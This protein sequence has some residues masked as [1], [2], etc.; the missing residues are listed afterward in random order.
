MPLAA[1][2]IT[3]I[4][5]V[6]RFVPH[7]RVRHRLDYGGATTLAIG[8]VP[9]SSSPNRAALGVDRPAV[10][11]HV[12]ARGRGPDPLRTGGTPDGDAALLP[13]RL[14]RVRSFRLGTTLHFIVAIGMFGATT[15]LP[16]YLQLVRGMSPMRAGLATLPTVAANLVITLVVGRLISRTGRFKVHLVA[17]VGSFAV[18]MF[19]YATLSADSPLWYVAIGMVFMGAGLG[20]AMQTLTT[21]AQSEVPRKDMGPRPRR[22]TSSAP[23]AARWARRPSCRSCSRSR[24]RVSPTAWPPPWTT[25]PTANSPNSPPTRTPLRA[26]WAGRQRE[27]GGLRLPAHPGPAGRRPVPRRLRQLPADRVPVRRRGAPGGLPDR[28]VA[29]AEPDAVRRVG[30]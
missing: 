14:Y 17:G 19:V 16:L 11:G 2:A 6:L 4:M 26:S 25:R 23:T 7:Q 10:P 15:T 30:A 8:L 29:G 28:G 12:R 3:V 27:P 18:A 21:L 1:V 22:S 20:A 24:A 5:R 9:C 13:L